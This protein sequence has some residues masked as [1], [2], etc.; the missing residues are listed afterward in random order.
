M[1]KKIKFDSQRFS[2]WKF[3]GEIKVN[4][5]I[6]NSFLTLKLNDIHKELVRRDFKGLISIKKSKEVNLETA[7]GGDQRDKT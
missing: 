6:S 5:S 4:I 7:A 2:L 1:R 3:K